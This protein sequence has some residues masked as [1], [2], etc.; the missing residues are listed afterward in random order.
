MES[1][2]ARAEKTPRAQFIASGLG[3]VE[4][5]LANPALFRL[6]FGSD[7]PNLRMRSLHK[8]SSAAFMVLVNDVTALTASDPMASDAG[9]L[10]VA[11]A[12]SLVHG[13]AN[14][15]IANRIG[16]LR[17]MLER[18]FEATMTGLIERIAPA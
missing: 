7:R 13:I 12:W 11:A 14:L 8:Q 6:M 18:D 17:P 16:F 1:R 15:L 10:T 9:Q 3:Y 4:F 2:H 5:A